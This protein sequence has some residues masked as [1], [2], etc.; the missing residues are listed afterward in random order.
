M[1]DRTIEAAGNA[2]FEDV[3]N[4][5]K[6]MIVFSTYKKTGFWSTTESGRRDEYR[7]IIYKCR[8]IADSLQRTRDMYCRNL[9]DIE[10]VSGMPD[11]EQKLCEIEGSWLRNLKI[12]GRT[13]WDIDVDAPERARPCLEEVIPS[14]WRYREDLLWLKY[15]QM[16]I[17]QKWKFRME[18]Q[19]RHDRRL[20]NKARED[21][22]KKGGH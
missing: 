10:D 20:R 6:A 7:G 15:R 22:A 19:Q 11:M 13:Y 8:P 14:D 18:E 1:G 21:R 4:N 3:T 16:K 5:Y 12:D 9:T 17:A 2:F